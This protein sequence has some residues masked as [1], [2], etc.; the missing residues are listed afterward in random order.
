[1]KATFLLI[2]LFII[3][4]SVF[5]QNQKYSRVNIPLKDKTTYS[6]L[7]SLGLAIDHGHWHGNSNLETDLSEWE[8]KQL[9]NNQFDYTILIED[10]KAHYKKINLEVPQKKPEVNN[11][12]TNNSIVNYPTPTNFSLGSMGGFF[13]YQEI[14]NH[15]DQ[16][17]I[18]YPN[19][20]KARSPID[21]FR[22]HENRP[23]FWLRISDNPNADENEPEVFYN[24]IHHARE[25]ASVAQLIMYMWYLLENYATNPEVQ[26]IVN[27]LELYFVPVINP[28]GYV[29]N[30]TTNPTGGGMWRKN[31]RNNGDG[32]FGVDLNRNYGNAWA[33]DNTGSS[34]NTNSDTYRGPSAFSEPETKAIKWFCEQHEFVSAL[35]YHTFGNLLIYPWGHIADFYTPDSATFVEH[36]KVLTKYNRYNYG[37]GDQTV[38]YL[39][40]GDSDNWMYGEQSS[41]N[42]IL[43][44]TPEA[45]NPEWGF[46][47][48]QSEIINICKENIYQNITLAKLALKFLK[49]EDINPNTIP[50]N[51]KL[52][53]KFKSLGIGNT[54][55]FTVN[56]LPISGIQFQNPSFN[57]QNLTHLEEKI[58][59]LTYTINSNIAPGAEISFVIRTFNNSIYEY[60]T[61]Y[62]TVGNQLNV[63]TDNCSTTTTFNLT[64]NW[65]TTAQTFVSSPR[66]ITDSP[67]G[68]YQ[69]F[70]NS[71]IT[72]KDPVDLTGTQNAS[73]QFYA[74]WEIETGYDYVVIEAEEN[75]NNIW[76]PLCGKYT[77]NGNSNQLQDQPIYD[78]NQPIWI[79]EEVDLKQFIGKKIK[80]RFRLVS[81]NFE[82]ADGFYF[83]DLSISKIQS[84]GVSVEKYT[85]ESFE[86]FPNPAKSEFS[87]QTN[88]DY[89][90]V[91]LLDLLGNQ[92]PIYFTKNNSFDISSLKNG[93]YLVEFEINKKKTIRKKIIKI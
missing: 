7:L 51:G 48:P 36:A 86:I 57:F 53:F 88:I 81:D 12:Q 82:R 65:N 80:I 27:N 32:T 69:N 28:D 17:A 68:N 56:L 5:S 55:Q 16:M 37:T 31:R 46:W 25:P 49:V 24:A 84:S 85:N 44:I 26:F 67:N 33:W 2:T 89:T 22:T 47:P 13:T 9:Q 72:L 71:A 60:D 35:N 58:D 39:V 10:V 87:I 29:Y 74:K 77:K 18:Q 1:M 4:L 64:N 11:C 70:T 73:M 61:I 50:F 19:I 83:D 15:L 93:V 62:K 14:L 76:L 34:P 91:K 66:S 79:L 42:K 52:S 40:N 20:V 23:I 6:Q 21:T 54:N 8:I 92:V 45:G 63:L 90:S 78:G 3:T 43:S 30:Q 59:S 38:G 41:K 75:D